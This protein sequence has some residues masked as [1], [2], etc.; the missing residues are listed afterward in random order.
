MG[1]GKGMKKCAELSAAKYTIH[2]SLE[3][4]CRN[5]QLFGDSKTVCN[6]I[7]KVTNCHAFSLGHIMEEIYRLINLLEEFSCQHTYKE[8]NTTANL[9]SKEAAQKPIGTWSILEQTDGTFYQ[10]YHRPFIEISEQLSSMGD[11]HISFC[12][13]FCCLYIILYEGFIEKSYI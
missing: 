1:L 13:I 4:Q 12:Y 6:W 2:V 5:L 9:L 11:E 8:W 7:N 3:K 10:Y